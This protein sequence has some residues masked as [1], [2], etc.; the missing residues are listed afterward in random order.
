M[1][2]PWIGSG[3]SGQPKGCCWTGRSSGGQP[4]TAGHVRA[5]LAQLGALGLQAPDGGSLT[6]ALTDA[7]GGL[8]AT[9][10]RPALDRLAR[11]GCRDHPDQNCAC[12]VLGRPSAT[13]AYSP[14]GAQDAWVRTRDRTCR[15]PHCGQ[16]ADWADLDHV[17]PHACGGA[18][19]CANLCCLC[20]THHRL[21]TFAR[22]W[23]FVLDADGVLHVTTPSGITRTTR[24][25]GT[26]PPQQPELAV[27]TEPARDLPT[28]PDDDPPPF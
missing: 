27:E 5:L 21:K 10:T 18:T 25:P 11:R 7:D 9:A 20:R 6:V 12:P 17:V 23:R 4:I 1:F 19:D 26:R 22:G 24:P 2:A 16:R 28:A 15:F 14:T 8:L 3:V 13:A